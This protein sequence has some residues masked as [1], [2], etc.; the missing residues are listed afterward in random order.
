MS[1]I[2]R[3]TALRAAMR[4]AGVDIYIVPSSDAHQSEY[5]PGVWQRRPWISGF[6]GSMGDCVVGLEGAWQWADSRYWLQAEAELDPG[7]WTL[8]KQG[9][10]GVLDLVPW[11]GKRPAGTVVGYDP[12]LVGLDQA[13]AIVAAVEGAGG[14]VVAIEENLVDQVW[15]DQPELPLGPIAPWP[16]EHAGRSVADK[17][18]DIRAALAEAG[19]GALVMTNLD[20]IGWAF[21]VRGADVDY[22]PVVIAYAVVGADDATLFVDPRRA[23]A[24]LTAHLAAAGARVAPYE[25]FG[26]A[27]EGLGETAR[28]VWVDPEVASRWVVDRLEAGGA[29]IHARMSPIM[30]LRAVKNAVERDGMRACHVRDAVA[31]VRFFHWIE[32][33]WQDGLDEISASDRL[34]AFRAEGER[35]VGLSFGTISGFGSNGAI[36]HYSA[37]PA[38]A[39]VIDDS[40]LYLLDSGAQ[41]LDGTTDITRTMHLGT[42][43]AE[44]REHY[45]RVLRGH[46]QLGRARFPRGTTGTHLDALAR[47][48]LWEVG[49]NYGHGTGHG[50]G[51]YLGVHQGPH[52]IS[53][54]PNAIGLEPGMVT[55]NE[56][57]LYIAGAYGIRIENLCL[58]V[59]AGGPDAEPFYAFED[60]TVVPYCRKLIEPA[61]LNEVERAQ[62][63]AYHARVRDLLLDKV[64]AEVAAWLENETAP[65]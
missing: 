21:N 55:S 47:T 65:L 58:V 4:A 9:Y 59:P 54:R 46:L 27:L 61:L 25:S 50:V 39:K 44:Q 8:M 36:V 34:E 49:L 45:T 29:E 5:V 43:T 32:G 24:A 19:A 18:A 2:D 33:A 31:M 60:L 22:N 12:R 57:G 28:R 62:V 56:P 11:L 6:T 20:A 40:T 17:L 48:P 42:P 37:T 30:L 16:L 23:D 38:T 15:T 35:F 3:V 63:N 10:A 53:P 64:P 51:C 7:V 41:Y 1:A 26:A 14:R 13:T 52:R